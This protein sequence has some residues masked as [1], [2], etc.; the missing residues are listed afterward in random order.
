MMIYKQMTSQS[1]RHKHHE[2]PIGSLSVHCLVFASNGTD[3]CGG[4]ILGCTPTNAEYNS[5][6]WPTDATILSVILH[7]TD[8]SCT[9]SCTVYEWND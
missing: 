9:G 2:V 4:G 6:A 7:H 8:S 3:D 1:C 5:A